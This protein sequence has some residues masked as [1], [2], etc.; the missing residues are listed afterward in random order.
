MLIPESLIIDG[1][2]E[3]DESAELVKVLKAVSTVDA[4]RTLIFSRQ[5]EAL[6][7]DIEMQLSDSFLIVNVV[8]LNTDDINLY[9]T[10][11]VSDL[12]CTNPTLFSPELQGRVCARILAK[13]QGMFQWVNLVLDAILHH[14][15]SE[16]DIMKTLE[17]YPGKLDGAYSKTFERLQQLPDFKRTRVLVALQWLTCTIRP[18]RLQELK[19]AIDLHEKK[20]AA[21]LVSLRSDH[22]LLAGSGEEVEQFFSFLGPLVD[23]RSGR[24]SHTHP[25]GQQDPESDSKTIEICHHSLKQ[26]IR[27]QSSSIDKTV[28]RR[29][30]FGFTPN[31]AH[32][33][34]ALICLKLLNSKET[35]LN[36]F[37]VFY[38]A[39]MEQI[40]L[41]SYAG[42][43]F[44]YHLRASGINSGK[45]STGDEGYDLLDMMSSSLKTNLQISL[46]ILSALSLAVSNI[47]QDELQHLPQIVA[48][49]DLQ[50]NLLSGTEAL[51]QLL[52]VLSKVQKHLEMLVSRFKRDSHQMKRLGSDL[53]E[54]SQISDLEDEYL[55]AELDSPTMMQVMHKLQQD[56]ESQADLMEQ[57]RIFQST[58]RG[59]RRVTLFISV[60]P[61]RDWVYRRIGNDGTSPIP[62]LA[63][64]S[65]AID[66]YLAAF[67]LP[68][69]RSTQYDFRNQ[70]SA[71][72]NH[73]FYG[74]ILSARYELASRG[75]DH[76]GAGFYKQYI[77]PLFQ[78]RRW[79]WELLR[80][81]LA[82][83]ETP[84]NILVSNPGQL[85]LLRRWLSGTLKIGPT[86]D[87][88]ADVADSSRVLKELRPLA[89]S[90][91]LTRPGEIM[92]AVVKFI[93]LTLW[94]VLALI[95]PYLEAL[96]VRS[97]LMI[98][99]R[100]RLAVPLAKGLRQDWFHASLA[101]IP[102]AIRLQ[103]FPWL[104]SSVRYSPIRDLQDISQRPFS[105]DLPIIR[106]KF[107]LILIGA[108]EIIIGLITFLDSVCLTDPKLAPYFI[109]VPLYRKLQQRRSSPADEKRRVRQYNII[110]HVT[111]LFFSFF[112]IIF[113]ERTL[114]VHLYL[115]HDLIKMAAFA[116][117]PTTYNALLIVLALYRIFLSTLAVLLGPGKFLGLVLGIA[118]IDNFG[119]RMRLDSLS[120]WGFI[121][122]GLQIVVNFINLVLSICI[123]SPWRFAVSIFQ[124]ISPQ[125]SPSSISSSIV[126]P[127]TIKTILTTPSSIAILLSIFILTGFFLYS[128]SDPL[129]LRY[130][131]RSA[132]KTARI[133]MKQLRIMGAGAGSEGAQTIGGDRRKD[134]KDGSAV[135]DIDPI[136]TLGWRKETA[137]GMGTGMDGGSSGRLRI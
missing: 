21:A 96:V 59:L 11:G 70:F 9:V 132:E 18:L 19:M 30:A 105:L 90:Y 81:I 136:A 34:A 76:L 31:E 1:L 104:F 4:T 103:R 114:Y 134:G 46:T 97:I 33:Q 69:S 109:P 43:F 55:T 64:A 54:Y 22:G 35:L 14:G 119:K 120:P 62:A 72:K 32:T 113:L 91:Q 127:T 3:S 49:R 87:S 117:H 29:H 79:E 92:V 5:D 99:S 118:F 37:Q 85:I 12:A 17:H 80:I 77:L 27:R 38:D 115:L 129:N 13:A 45:E 68:P 40:P 28:S 128:M 8:G 26:W 50:N 58:A 65:A 57:I 36:Y 101:L 106:P 67:M 83:L 61:I 133:T 94:K 108:H 73:Q 131:R 75:A 100:Y 124:K 63:H 48:I 52:K 10:Q 122:R 60:N 89:R 123:F 16:D 116:T 51:V 24:A 82:I 112:R 110:R 71:A 111:I 41:L 7:D 42:D 137:M 86:Y 93:I 15:K 56:S 66:T 74:P 121:D 95:V 53:Y 126:S 47:R 39:E 135:N 23:I 88:T 102:Y 44:G 6:Q 84:Q 20:E 78:V 130:A 25:E 2:D 107:Q 98:G 125:A